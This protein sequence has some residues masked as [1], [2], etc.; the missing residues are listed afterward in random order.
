MPPDTHSESERDA[1]RDSPT[2]DAPSDEAPVRD[3]TC[4]A[5]GLAVTLALAS[6]FYPVLLLVSQP[7]AYLSTTVFV[8]LL[9]LIWF[10][11]WACIET[12][13]E[14]RSGRLKRV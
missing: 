6:V 10:L 3:Y 5:V 4:A 11:V 8:T 7:F 9:V 13:W 12:A 1:R 2:P 14:W